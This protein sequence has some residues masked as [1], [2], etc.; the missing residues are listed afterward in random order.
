L[1]IVHLICQDDGIEDRE[2]VP[3][4]RDRSGLR[5]LRVRMSRSSG[6]ISRIAPM[7]CAALV[8]LQLGAGGAEAQQFPWDVPGYQGPSAKQSPPAPKPQLPAVK[9]A[10]A[11]PS[12]PPAEPQRM[13]AETQAELTRAKTQMDYRDWDAAI[14]TLATVLKREPKSAIALLMRGNA[15]TG[16]GE[17]DLA[18]ADYNQAIKLESTT[19]A[20]ANRAIAWQRKG[21]VDKAVADLDKALLLDPRN[22]VALVRRAG[23]ARRKGDVDAAIRDYDLALKIKPNDAE[24]ASLRQLAVDERGQRPGAPL[25]ASAGA[26]GRS[27]KVGEQKSVDQKVGK[28][29]ANAAPEDGNIRKAY[30][31]MSRGDVDPAI[32]EFDRALVANPRSYVALTG[33]AQ[34]FAMRQRFNDAMADVNAALVLNKGF[35]PIHTIRGLVFLMRGEHDRA[36]AALDEAVKLDGSSADSLAYRGAA[37][38]AKRKPDDA[39]KDLDKAL[40][41]NATLTLALTTRGKLHAARN[42]HGKAV[43]DFDKALRQSPNMLNTTL[44]RGQSYEALGNNEQ[45]LADYN[46]VLSLRPLNVLDQAEQL[47]AKK[48]I[49]A[50]STTGSST[51]SKARGETCL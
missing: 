37:F 35:P 7:A 12:A 38:F 44:Q 50:L 4:G 25:A 15:Y 5:G 28:P 24:I 10:A 46:K 14:T 17:F 11:P 49:D 16:K 1:D 19:I 33:R 3:V 13:S 31:L 21:D 48:R 20:Y 29:A 30:E 45:A 34:A 18:L 47:V 26:A 9:P 39:L 22:A 2:G 8:M 36:I 40:S 43:A 6:G 27:Q 23:I 51:C 32:A 42:D 41:I